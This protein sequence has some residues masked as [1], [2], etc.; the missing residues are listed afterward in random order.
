MPTRRAALP[1]TPVAVF[2]PSPNCRLAEVNR[3]LY[4]RNLPY[5]IT[6]EDMYGIFGRYGA[7]RQVRMGDTQQTKGTAYVIYEDIY[8]ARN[9]QG[10]L[11]G[12][13]LKNRYLVVNYHQEK[14]LRT[15]LSVEEQEEELRRM[16]EAAGVDGAQH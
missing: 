3:V 13:N 14:N 2:S 1:W 10:Q 5:D 7:I 11:S 16:Q 8:D 12:Y 4:V 6:D 9:A 15:K